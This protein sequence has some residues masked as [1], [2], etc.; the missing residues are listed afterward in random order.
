MI[1]AFGKGASKMSRTIVLVLLAYVVLIITAYHPFYG[2]ITEKII[3]NSEKLNIFRTMLLTMIGS[4]FNIEVMYLGQSSLVYTASLY[5]TESAINMQAIIMQ[6]M[7]GL[8]M[9]FIPT[10][11]LLVIGL[12]YFDISY[13]K[14]LKLVWKLLVVLLLII[15]ATVI[16]VSKI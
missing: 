4:F 9:L 10:S 6:A 11:S 8:T 1:E 12:D 2:T 5:A 13:S 15:V 3:G 7:Y 14:W 16:I